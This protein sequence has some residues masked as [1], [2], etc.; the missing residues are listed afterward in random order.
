[1]PHSITWKIPSLNNF[2]LSYIKRKERFALYALNLLLE[3][4]C[5]INEQWEKGKKICSL[6]DLLIDFEQ[7]LDCRRCHVIEWL[8]L[9]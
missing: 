3:N 9:M 7:T 2:N 5:Q 6:K 1:M 8:F 4:I